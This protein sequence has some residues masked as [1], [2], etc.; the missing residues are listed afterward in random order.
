MIFTWQTSIL[1][2]QNGCTRLQV[3]PGLMIC[4]D[5]ELLIICRI[6]QERLGRSHHQQKHLKILHQQLP[7]LQDQQ[8]WNFYSE[9]SQIHIDQE[10][11]TNSN[12]V[13]EDTEWLEESE[14]NVDEE[15]D[16]SKEL[17]FTEELE[18]GEDLEPGPSLLDK[19]EV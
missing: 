15:I 3:K 2:I 16:A 19:T 1:Q 13:L 7:I 10:L 8:P 6:I 18:A 4:N 12:E 11:K 14:L 17:D 9:E 5:S